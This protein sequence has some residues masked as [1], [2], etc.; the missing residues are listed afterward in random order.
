MLWSTVYQSKFHLDKTIDMK[1]YKETKQSLLLLVL[2]LCPTVF[3]F[4]GCN[5]NA[6]QFGGNNPKSGY[7]ALGSGNLLVVENS[8][9]TLSIPI[10]LNTSINPN[11][12]NIRYSVEA[13]DGTL[14]SGFV[15]RSNGSIIIKAGELQNMLDFIVPNNSGDYSFR[16]NLVSVDDPDFKLGLND[17]SKVIST[18]V[19]VGTTDEIIVSIDENPALGQ[20][21]SQTV[22]NQVDGLSFSLLAE[23][24]LGSLSVDPDSG[25]IS[26]LDPLAF[27]WEINPVLTGVVEIISES[28]TI[29]RSITINLNDVTNFWTGPM[30]TFV[31]EGDGDAILPEN[32]DR[33]TDNV[34]ITRGSAF[35][36]YNAAV[37][38][39]FI[40]ANN[41]PESISP[42][43]TLWAVGSITDG[44]ENLNFQTFATTIG[45]AYQYI[46]NRGNQPLVLY[47]VKDDT[48]INLIWIDWHRGNGNDGGLGGF[49]YQRSTQ[50]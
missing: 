36:I 15:D 50:N 28:S 1:I 17:G 32:Q 39:A 8:V 35:P 45:S 37:E 34:W 11:G 42:E 38:S 21:L 33:I 27:D 24:I 29:S 46:N 40:F 49:S 4:Y 30:T 9:G 19:Y 26:V 48:Y 44:I 10:D 3:L 25:E 41:Y 14:P 5:D 22:F 23:S 43:R 13:I 47:L 16:I 18:I 6:D 12:V 2:Y 31:Y 20:E 7:V